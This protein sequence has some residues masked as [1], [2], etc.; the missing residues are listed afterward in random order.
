MNLSFVFY[1]IDIDWLFSL[2]DTL[3]IRL[4]YL[5]SFTIPSNISRWVF[6]LLYRKK[7]IL[8]VMDSVVIWLLLNKNID[9]LLRGGTMTWPKGPSFLG[10]IYR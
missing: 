9:F 7:K 5:S 2:C 3:A 1:R 8:L 6:F 4:R 10:T